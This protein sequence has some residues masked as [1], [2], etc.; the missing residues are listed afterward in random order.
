M[1]YDA[2]TLDTNTVER[3]GFS[4]ESGLLGQLSQFK[5]GNAELIL[6]EIVGREIIKHMNRSASELR[7]QLKTALQKSTKLG[8]IPQDQSEVAEALKAG[9]VAPEE[10]VKQR[11]E[12]FVDA[13]GATIVPAEYAD[14]K[15]LVAHYFR[16]LPPFEGAG[17][18]KNEFPD[19]IALLSLERWGKENNKRILAISEDGGWSDFAN[20]SE[21]IDVETDLAKAL[22]MFQALAEEAQKTVAGFLSGLVRGDLSDWHDHLESEVFSEITQMTPYGHAD[23]HLHVEVYEIDLEPK[24]FTLIGDEEGG[25][26]HVVRVG[27]DRITASVLAEIEFD[28][29]GSADFAVY[30]SIDKEY[31]PMG[32]NSC[33]ATV[34]ETFPILVEFLIRHGDEEEPFEIGKV[35]FVEQIEDIDFGYIEPDW[36][37]ERDEYD[38]YDYSE[39]EPQA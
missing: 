6:S 18:K 7:D 26:V 25:L 38:T 1:N 36:R 23:S 17:K 8:L 31:V 16:P 3:K 30:D 15:E 22:E 27:K 34:K 2:I 29:N 14:M 4:F 5:E 10:A 11:F 13:T 39:A 20:N 19:A 12:K 32:G 37:D 24:A 21:W 9:L 35:E 33:H 28:A